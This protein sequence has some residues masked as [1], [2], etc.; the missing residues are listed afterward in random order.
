MT[1]GPGLKSGVRIRMDNPAQLGRGAAVR[2]G[3]R[4]APGPAAADRDEPGHRRHHAGGG[5]RRQ[6]RGRRHPARPPGL[7]LDALVR[8]T[9]Q[10]PQ[11]ELET[12]PKAL[13]GATPPTACTAAS[14][15]APPPCWTAW[16]PALPGSWARRRPRS[17]PPAACPKAS[18]PPAAPPIRY[19]DTLI[20]DGLFAIWQRNARR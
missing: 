3:G 2:G 6:H 9:A 20:L 16:Q 10:L 14:S 12:S 18:A 17:S 8:N 1:V 4:A 11:V 19:R 7:A 13:F 5:R 15:T